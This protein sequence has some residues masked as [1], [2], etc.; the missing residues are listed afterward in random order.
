MTSS[1]TS[2]NHT[3]EP[4]PAQQGRRRVG[5]AGHKGAVQ[6]RRGLPFSPGLSAE[7]SQRAACIR[8][9]S[10]ENRAF[11]ESRA[12]RLPAHSRPPTPPHPGSCCALLLPRTQP[13]PRTRSRA[14]APNRGRRALRGA[15]LR[16]SLATSLGPGRESG[17]PRTAPHGHTR[18]RVGSPGLGRSAGSPAPGPQ[19]LSKGR[20]DRGLPGTAHLGTSG[21]SPVQVPRGAG[22]GLPTASDW[23]R[24]KPWL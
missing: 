18:G 22:A 1:G 3:P 16:H 9:V 17:R 5:D 7:C 15:R 24:V 6:A 2:A 12:K 4:R 19:R 14:A 8:T 13:P 11:P 23:A 21:D 20:P 10:D